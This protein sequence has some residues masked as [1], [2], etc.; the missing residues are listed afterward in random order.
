MHILDLWDYADIL[1]NTTIMQFDYDEI[2]QVKQFPLSKVKYL[3][4]RHNKINIIDDMAFTNLK[5]LVELDLSYN[6]LTSEKLKHN[7]FKVGICTSLTIIINFIQ[8]II[9]L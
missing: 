8:C 5:F 9:L 3:S 6:S 4:L 1:K 7:V 2:I